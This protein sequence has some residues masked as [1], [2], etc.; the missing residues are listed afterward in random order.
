MSQPSTQASNAIIYL[1]YGGFLVMGCYVAWKLRHQTTGEFLSSNRTQTAL[2]LALNF[3][4]ASLGSS[5]L[6]SYPQLA[7][8]VGVQGVIIYAISSAAPL[9][10]FAF[11]TPIIRKKCPEGFVLTEWTRQRYGVVTAIYLSFMTMATMFLYMVAELSAL[12]QIMT[13]LT[14]MD[15]LPMVIV[16]CAVT[17]IYTSVGGFKI[18]FITDNI[19]ATMVISLIIIATITIGVQT[20]IDKS[21]RDNSVLLEPSKLGWQLLYILPVSI[22]TNVFFLS[23]FWIRAFAAKTDRDLWT[24]VTIATL[25]VLIILTLV[26]VTG[27]IATWSGAYDPTNPDQDGSIAFFLLLESLPTWTIGLILVIVISMST[28]AFDSIQSA[29]VSTASND[30]FRNKLNIWFIRASVV[31]LIFPVVVIALKSPSVLRIYLISNLVST[32]TIPVL[33]LG[34]MDRFYWWRGFE[35]VVGGLG[36]LLSVFVFGT[37]YFGDAEQGANLLIIDSGLFANDWSVFGAFVAAPVGSI[38]WGFGA[39]AVRLGYRF[40]EAKVK[41]HRF[42]ALDRPAYMQERAEGVTDYVDDHDEVHS[43]APAGLVAVDYKSKFF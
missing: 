21:L 39:L 12:Q 26:G 2:P 40:V 31:L 41:G 43:D 22:I 7:T 5:I 1:T 33:V 4:A 10:V 11:L 19:Q 3:I 15:G 29:M 9:L 32:S 34:L 14:G 37:I 8:I 6:F 30:L 13:A 18:S 38:L 35:V 28:A 20:K 23:S 42:D 25:V 27:L 17:T 24:G 36:G 16:Q